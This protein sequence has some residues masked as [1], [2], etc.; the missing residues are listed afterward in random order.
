[1]KRDESVFFFTLVDFLLTVLFFGLVLFAV[2]QAQ[3]KRTSDLQ[4]EE[5]TAIAKVREATGISDLTELTDRLTRLGPIANAEEA[6]RLVTEVGG[7]VAARRLVETTVA[8]G[9]DDSVIAR[10]N[11]LQQR[12]G[13][14]KPFCLFTETPRGKE[15]VLLATVVADD[16]TITFRQETPALRAL[17][18]RLGQEFSEVESLA[19]KEFRRTF[20]RVL[21]IEP[22]CLYTIEFIERTRYVDARDAARGLFYLRIRR[23]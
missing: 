2:R 3:A 8:A 5:G 18:E 10:L 11:R 1:M 12:E 7:T 9:G 14:G 13:A 6:V 19:L 15:S 22:N 20:E 17:L 16:S 4:E 23:E 21:L